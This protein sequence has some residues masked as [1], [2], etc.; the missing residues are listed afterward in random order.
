[1]LP[2]GGVQTKK[3]RRPKLRLIGTLVQGLLADAV[4][5]FDQVVT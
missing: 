4:L 2:P 1:M 3:R 5:I